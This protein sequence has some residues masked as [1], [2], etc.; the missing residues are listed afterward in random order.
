MFYTEGCCKVAH[1]PIKLLS[2]SPLS[3]LSPPNIKHSWSFQR[4]NRRKS[5]TLSSSSNLHLCSYICVALSIIHT[6]SLCQTLYL[7]KPPTPFVFSSSHKIIFQAKP[8]NLAHV[9]FVPRVLLKLLLA[10]SDCTPVC[11]KLCLHT[12]LWQKLGAADLHLTRPRWSHKVRTS[13]TAR[14]LQ[15]QDVY[16]SLPVCVISGLLSYT[17][18]HAHTGA[19]THGEFKEKKPAGAE[20]KSFSQLDMR[21][22]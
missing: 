8:A 2:L 22:C 20:R 6:K 7:Y 14:G 4:S 11:V 18:A 15:G 10:G 12:V 16:K 21:R 13:S 1:W 3:S 17:H 9:L 5:N 19:Y